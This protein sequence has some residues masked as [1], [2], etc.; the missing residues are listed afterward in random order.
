ML[1]SDPP[2]APSLRYDR[3]YLLSEPKRNDVLTLQEV[4]RYGTDSFNDRDYVA[5]YGLKPA[6]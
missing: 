4:I 2:D 1:V 6:D 5:L 3:A